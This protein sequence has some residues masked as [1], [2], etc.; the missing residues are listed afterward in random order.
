MFKP[1]SAILFGATLGF[2]SLIPLQALT[3]SQAKAKCTASPNTHTLVS[4]RAFAGDANYC[5]D[6]R[7]MTP[8]QVARYG[9][10]F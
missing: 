6:N 7:Y 8:T 2:I 1:L 4:V 3:N 9:P 5:L 10:A